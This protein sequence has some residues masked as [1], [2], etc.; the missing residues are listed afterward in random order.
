MFVEGA[1]G[2]G[3]PEVVAAF[4]RVVEPQRP[5]PLGQKGRTGP[6]L[7]IEEI[8]GRTVYSKNGQTAR[9]NSQIL[10]T[11]APPAAV[12]VLTNS[13]ELADGSAL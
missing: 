8:E 12:V 11:I 13:R 2:T 7:N 6:L 1:L 4:Q 5:S 9:F 3:T 10:F